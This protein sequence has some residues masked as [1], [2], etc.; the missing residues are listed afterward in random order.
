MTVSVRDLRS[1]DLEAVH[2]MLTSL[3]VIRGTMRLPHAPLDLTRKRLEHRSGVIKLVAE[4]EG[5]VV[6][7][8]ELITYP[9]LPRHNHA[10]EV[11]VIIVREDW[12][13]KGVAR[14]LMQEMIDLAENWLGLTRLS[15]IVWT[16]NQRAI[17]IYERFG[18]VVE[19]T[20]R[21]YAFRDG[22]YIDAQLMAR[23]NR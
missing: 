1:E 4:A 23:I 22:E 19:G 6:G 15:L 13:G 12:Q 10:G 3:H 21:N 16:S 2:E 18:F 7:F 5:S 9:D 11:N 14:T 8:G 20:M 17:D